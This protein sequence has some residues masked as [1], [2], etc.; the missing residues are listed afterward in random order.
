[1]C[2]RDRFWTIGYG[3]TQWQDG[4]AVKEGQ[5]LS[6][7]KAESLLT[8]YVEKFASQVKVNVNQNEFD[9]LVS[10]AYNVGI[11]AF[12]RSTLKKMII[13]NPG[14]LLIKDEFMK[15]VAKGSPYEKGLTNRRKAESDLYFK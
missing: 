15:W 9:A 1:M 4:Q 7:Y 10:F 14:N 11:G 12:N 13:E 5:E 6:L 2:I 3:N 8:F